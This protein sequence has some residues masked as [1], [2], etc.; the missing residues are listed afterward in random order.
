MVF[1]KPIAWVLINVTKVSTIFP[2]RVSGQGYGIGPVCL[3]VCVS[4]SQRSPGWTV[5][6]R[7]TKLG[8][9]HV[10][11]WHL[12]ILS[13]L[14]GKNTDKQCTARQGASMLRHFHH[15]WFW[16]FSRNKKAHLQCIGSA[17]AVQFFNALQDLAYAA[18]TL[19]HRSQCRCSV[20]V[21][22]TAVR[23]EWDVNL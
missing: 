19:L 18:S 21:H 22:Y 13:R 5:W 23:S 11:A 14:L 2:S 6:P 1:Y 15:L 10:T 8:C 17:I 7:V 3:W 20:H 4:V 16:L 9:H 12:D